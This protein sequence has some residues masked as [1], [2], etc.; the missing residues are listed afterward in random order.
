M[1]DRSYLP[2][3]SQSDQRKSIELHLENFS[4]KSEM[5]IAYDEIILAE[6][7]GRGAFGRVTTQ[8]EI[9]FFSLILI[10]FF[11]FF[12]FLLGV[13]R[14]SMESKLKKFILIFG[15]FLR[16]FLLLNLVAFGYCELCN[17]SSVRRFGY[18]AN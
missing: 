10:F 7:I 5:E 16:I 8:K 2:I 17:Q 11:F 3:P 9:L 13:Q 15:L 14:K 18:Q 4:K 6:E 12:G 1:S